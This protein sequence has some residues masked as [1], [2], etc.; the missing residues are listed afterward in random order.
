MIERKKKRM[1]RKMNGKWE[2]GDCENGGGKR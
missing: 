2:K 1:E